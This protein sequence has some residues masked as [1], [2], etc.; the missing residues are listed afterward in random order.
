MRTEY[1]TEVMV[2][3]V[4]KEHLLIDYRMA[5]TTDAACRICPHYAKV[6]SCPPDFPD[7]ERLLAPYSYVNLVVCKVSY[8][9]AWRQAG[10]TKEQIQSFRDVSYEKVKRGLLMTLVALEA[11]V[12]GSICAGAGRCI[13]CDRCTRS[14][15]RPCRR[16]D[17]LRYSF[18][19]FRFDAAKLL[20]DFFDT[21]LLWRADGLPA[22]DI[23]LGALFTGE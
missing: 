19:G 3:K 6:W 4:R 14:E 1:R 17:Q 20:A 2:K 18:T 10:F 7:T 15:G 22:Y 8:G 13:L 23:A 16:P 11:Y 12:P 21:R 9:D 5:D